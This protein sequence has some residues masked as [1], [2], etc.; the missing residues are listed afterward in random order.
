MRALPCLVGMLR[1]ALAAVVTRL[2]AGLQDLAAVSLLE[3]AAATLKEVRASH[4]S[5]EGI[6][7]VPDMIRELARDRDDYKRMAE[8][9]RTQLAKVEAEVARL[10]QLPCKWRHGS[11]PER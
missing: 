2:R 4:W 7:A 8:S 1:S 6:A 9:Y 5:H 10:D 3:E 11:D